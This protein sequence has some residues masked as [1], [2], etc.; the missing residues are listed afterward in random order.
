MT[1]AGAAAITAIVPQM[2]CS[3]TSKCASFSRR[4]ILTLPRT[5]Q[6][7][8]LYLGAGPAGVHMA[9]HRH[10]CVV[11]LSPRPRLSSDPTQSLRTFSDSSYAPSN[12]TTKI[13]KSGA[14]ACATIRGS[15]VCRRPTHP[16]TRPSRRTVNSSTLASGMPRP[17][18]G[19]TPA[20]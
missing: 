16:S 18:P 20:K 17:R 11:S 8:R 6:T 2:T 1:I 9:F 10:T 5:A 19:F 15:R 3:T 12:T 7:R 13:A 4:M 14:A